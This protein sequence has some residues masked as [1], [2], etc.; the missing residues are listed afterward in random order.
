M[1]YVEYNAWEYE[2]EKAKGFCEFIR[3]RS[4]RTEHS[5]QGRARRFKQYADACGNRASLVAYPYRSLSGWIAG[6]ASELCAFGSTWSHSRMSIV[7]HSCMMRKHW[8]VDTGI[9]LLHATEVALC[10]TVAVRS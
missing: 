2:Q 9:P 1:A 6:P 7:Q 5:K 8:A 4:G 3:Q 10:L